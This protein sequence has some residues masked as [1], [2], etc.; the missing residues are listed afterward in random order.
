MRI[1]RGRFQS[2]DRAEEMLLGL[3]LRPAR[4]WKPFANIAN[5]LYAYAGGT[6]LQMLLRRPALPAQLRLLLWR[7]A[8]GRSS[9]LFRPLVVQMRLRTLF[10]VQICR[11]SCLKALDPSL[12]VR[13][14]KTVV[15][16][17]LTDKTTN[18]TESRIAL[19]IPGWGSGSSFGDHPFL[20][21]FRREKL[22]L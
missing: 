6:G 15:S 9:R 16:G 14:P 21:S 17:S 19:V 10:V 11:G 5:T 1:R 7:A 8:F 3:S 18:A 4:D 13:I 12:M 22:L 2:C 20:I